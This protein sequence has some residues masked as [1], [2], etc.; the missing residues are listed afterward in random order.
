M[1]FCVTKPINEAQLAPLEHLPLNDAV[2]QMAQ[3]I[4]RA[5]ANAYQL[6]PTNMAAYEML[7]PEEPQNAELDEAK[8]WLNQRMSLLTTAEERRHLL[9]IYANPVIAKQQTKQS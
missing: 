6:M 3:M 8:A 7:H 5:I 9:H 1:H 4:D 2:R